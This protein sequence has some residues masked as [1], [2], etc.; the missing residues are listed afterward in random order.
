MSGGLHLIAGSKLFIGN[1]VTPKSTDLTPADFAGAT[2]TEIKGWASAGQTGDTQEIVEQTLIDGRRV[3]KMKGVLN[4]NTME[5]TFVPI[6]LD[7]GQAKFMAAI[8][9]NCG[10]YQFKV[11]WSG[12]CG[13]T[14]VVTISAATPGVVSWQ[15]HGLLAG[16]PVVFTTTGALPTGL[17]AG[18]VYYVIATGLTENSFS[19]GATPGATVGIDT[20]GAGTG[21]ITATA[22]PAGM[23]EM[24]YGLAASGA[25][26]GGEAN[27]VHLRTWSIAVNSNYV[28]V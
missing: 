9:D 23:T 2:W 18:T 25:R 16:Q 15:N 17:T 8:K 22:P 21:T 3:I 6:P 11:E 1:R 19:V 4:G 12:D 26:S 20:T 28:E 5:N 27:A 14:S 10:S 7:P 24:F 13:N